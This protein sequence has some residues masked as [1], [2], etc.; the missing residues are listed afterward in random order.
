LDIEGR[1]FWQV[2]AGD[3]SERA[4]PDLLLKWDIVAT[5]GG[6]YGRWPDNRDDYRNDKGEAQ[7]RIV[8]RFVSEMAIGDIVV[9]RLGKN[10]VYGVGIVE[11]D[12]LWLDDMGDVDGWN[13]QHCRRV[14][15][16]WRYDAEQSPKK[17][18]DNALRW[19]D[20]VQ[21]AT[22]PALTQW[23]KKLP[24]SKDAMSRALVSLP[25]TCIDAEY[26]FDRGTAAD[27]I[28]ALTSRMT[29][30]VRI[31][32]WYE[33]AK[34][35]PAERETVAYLVVP[36]LRSLG[37]TPQRMAIEWN[38]IDIALF[39]S[40]PRA[41]ENLI[42]A[43]EAKKR[44]RTCFTS[45]TQVFGYVSQP[46]RRHCIRAISTEGLRYS[47]F[48]RNTTDVFQ[49]VPTA[50]LNLTRLVA[51]YPLL[52]CA[53]AKE[54]LSMMASDWSGSVDTVNKKS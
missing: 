32:S 6:E 12:Y 38:R 28:D 54:A 23:V 11:S 40:L 47:V 51:D 3:A 22:S 9:L 13:L 10:S 20:T 27:N 36:L 17:F 39:N 4:Y 21:Q 8:E 24:V 31:A 49:S 19:G 5:G 37:W 25:D 53:G 14:K 26:L 33:R 43:V 41:D 48:K 29:D 50:Y 1:R 45:S 15:W 35:Q 7:V 30:L 46:E 18:P 2:A 42:A 44:G 16:L 34:M 52:G